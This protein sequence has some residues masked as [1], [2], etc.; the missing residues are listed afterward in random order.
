M[1]KDWSLLIL[2][3]LALFFCLYSCKRTAENSVTKFFVI[4]HAERFAGFDANLTWYG[5]LRA[6]D[7][8]RL[9][10]DSG[11]RRIYVTPFVRTQQTADSLRLLQQIDTVHY[12]ADT[13]GKDFARQLQSHTVYGSNA[14]IVGHANTVPVILRRLGAHYPGNTIPDTVFNLI[15]EVINDHGKVTLHEFHY[16]LPNEASGQ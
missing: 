11:I 7:L 12:L 9:L 3:C 14:L 4:R 8:M 10:K 6:G 1:R 15:F 5:R 16:G 2:L 13:S